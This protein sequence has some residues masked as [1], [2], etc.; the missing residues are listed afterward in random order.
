MCL[1]SLTPLCRNRYTARTCHSSNAAILDVPYEC[2]R[3][4]GY[5]TC[6]IPARPT[7][8]PPDLPPTPVPTPAPT[9]LGSRWNLNPIVFEGFS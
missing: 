1:V 8:R 2:E 6:N 9:M 4:Q 3:I 7:H 5:Y